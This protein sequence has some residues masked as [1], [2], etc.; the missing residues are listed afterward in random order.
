[1]IAIDTNMLVYDQRE[2]SPW[3]DI[4]YAPIVN[5]AEGRTQC[6]IPRP[7]IHDFFGHRNPPQNLLSSDLTACSHRPDRSQIGISQYY[8][9][10]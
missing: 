10:L 2:D 1:M 6:A 9:V 3:H 7:G 5:L 8:K 4:A